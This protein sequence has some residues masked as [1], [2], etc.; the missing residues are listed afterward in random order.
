MQFNKLNNKIKIKYS[1]KK[2]NKLKK[3]DLID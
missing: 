3:N 1:K 2:L